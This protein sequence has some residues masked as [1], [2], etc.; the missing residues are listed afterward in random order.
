MVV[1]HKSK[2]TVCALLQLPEPPPEVEGPLFLDNNSH[3]MCQEFKEK[4]SRHV[5]IHFVGVWCAFRILHRMSVSNDAYAGTLCPPS[6][7][8]E[9]RNYR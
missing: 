5:E 7:S 3:E 2:T 1:G 8:L 6:A 4:F 9:T